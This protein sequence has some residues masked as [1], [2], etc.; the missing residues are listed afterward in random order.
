MNYYNKNISNIPRNEMTIWNALLRAGYETY[1]VGGAVRDILLGNTPKDYDFATKATPAQIGQVFVDSEFKMDYVG[2]SFGVM[3]VAGV[4]VATFRGDRYFGNGDKDVEITYVDTIEEDLSRRD[5]TMNAM[6]LSIEGEL[7]D[8]F[9]G[10]DDLLGNDTPMIRFVGNAEDRIMEDPNRILRAFRFAASLGGIIDNDTFNAITKAV[11]DN[12]VSM[13]APERIRLEIMKTMSN[14]EQA[15]IFW[16]FLLSS[17][18]LREILPELADCYQHEHGNHHHEDV[19]THN[20]LA[21][22]YIEIDYPLTKLAGYLHDVGKPASYDPEN[23][24]FY[25]HHIL[26]ADIIRKRLTDLKF[27]NDEIRFVVNLIL[28]HMDGTR[29]MTAKAR[30]RLKNKLNRYGLHWEE[31]LAIRIADRHANLSRPDFTINQICDYIEMFTMEEEVPF[32]VNDLAVSG[33]D[34]IRIFHLEPG[35]IVGEIQ[36]EMLKFVIDHGEEFNNVNELIFN[37]GEIGF[38]LRADLE[39]IQNND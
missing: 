22:D 31:Y 2:A 9:W 33:G 7:I 29:E 30:R 17:G 10:E 6:A 23:G 39:E 32:S 20:M 26:G 15:S 4:E 12:V 28:I 38:G 36:R 11:D 3:I 37:I 27:S 35:P 8:P 18:I 24:T 25:E 13:I 14:A 19:W 16:D 34:I 5:F 1:L 21:G